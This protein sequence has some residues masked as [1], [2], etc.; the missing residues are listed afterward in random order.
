MRTFENTT[1]GEIIDNPELNQMIQDK[2]PEL[3]EHPLLEVGR[4]FIF[5]AVLPYIEDMITDELLE[6]IK[7]GL[8]KLD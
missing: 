8:A 5:E 4:P 7:E 1:I 3:L 2:N 6:M